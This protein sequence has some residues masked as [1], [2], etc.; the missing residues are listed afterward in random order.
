[1]RLIREAKLY[2]SKKQDQTLLT[3]FEDCRN[4]YNT[5]LETKI[6]AYQEEKKTLQRFELHKMFKNYEAN[7]PASLKQSIA[8]R[9]NTAFDRFFRKLGKYPRFKSKNRFRSIDLRQYKV[10]YRIKGNYL[11]TWKQI[12]YIRM[13]GLQ[14]LN[15]PSG[16]RIVKRATGWY[17]QVIDEAEVHQRPIENEKEVGIDMGIKYFLVDSDGNKIEPPNFFRKAQK[18]LRVAQ[19]KLKNKAKFSK[20][21]KKQAWQIAKIHERIANQRK[22]WLHKLSR[23]YA[24]NYSRVYA[25]NLNISG[26]LKN[27]HLAKS[28]SDAS[29]NMFLNMLSYKLQMLAGELV[30]V[31]AQYTSQKCSN[32]GELVQ[33]SLSVR[34]HLC[35]Y[36]GFV[37]DRDTNAAL[38]ILR[39]GQSRQA[40]TYGTSQSVA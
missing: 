12:G 3:L 8:S 30:C 39:L 21:W 5:I 34:T 17:L 9:V 25:E 1:M 32:C 27:R 33:K 13:M 7:I 14:K 22:D 2:P 11:S 29:W 28:I 16:A 20:R 31:P 23:K 10:D 18:K 40:L 24:N 38:N 4:L 6:K 26:M 19:R 36:C 37:S 35:P 15:N